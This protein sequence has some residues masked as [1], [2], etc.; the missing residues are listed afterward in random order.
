M[1]LDKTKLER[2]SGGGN[3]LHSY[4]TAADNKAAVVASGYFSGAT[5]NLR[6]NDFIFAV[7]SDGSQILVVTSA[8]GATPVTTAAVAAT[9]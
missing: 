9:A 8:T 7:C 2:Q 5:N 6:Q 4:V 1:A 3:Q